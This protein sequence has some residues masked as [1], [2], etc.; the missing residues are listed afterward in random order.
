M[1]PPMLLLLLLLLRHRVE[2]LIK[3]TKSYLDDR[4]TV[5][6][7]PCSLALDLMDR[8]G[9]MREA[10]NKDVKGL[11]PAEFWTDRSQWLES[12]MCG[13]AG[14]LAAHVGNGVLRADNYVTYAVEEAANEL[15]TPFTGQPHADA[16]KLDSAVLTDASSAVGAG[17][18]SVQ[19]LLN[20]PRVRLALASVSRQPHLGLLQQLRQGATLADDDL[21]NKVRGKCWHD[22]LELAVSAITHS[23]TTASRG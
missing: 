14:R 23:F 8:F 12:S 11:K 9:I 13:R 2:A 18:A 16:A 17:V 1:L 3:E 15:P 5:V 7:A 4:E 21:C 19:A 10:Q 22:M 20:G 6:A